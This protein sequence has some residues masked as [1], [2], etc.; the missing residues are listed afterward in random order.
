MKNAPYQLGDECFYQHLPFDFNR[1]LMPNQGRALPTLSEKWV[2]QVC[3]SET[4]VL[5]IKFIEA[6]QEASCLASNDSSIPLS[7]QLKDAWQA[8]TQAGNPHAFEQLPLDF[9]ASA[10]GDSS[11]TAFQRAV[12]Q[13][14]QGIPCGGT[15]TYGQLAV[16]VGKPMG[17]S[18]AVGGALAKNPVPLIIPC[19]RIKPQSGMMTNFCG[20]PQLVELK[21]F[22]LAWENLLS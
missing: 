17:A 8:Y 1:T 18:R 16:A 4:A 20:S 14:V 7:K 22:L 10:S 21:Q 13:A 6:F 9:Q 15:K 12:W 3:H 5:Q 11:P 2:V 19:H